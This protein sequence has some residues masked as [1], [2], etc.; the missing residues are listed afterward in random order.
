MIA[1]LRVRRAHDVVDVGARLEDQYGVDSLGSRAW[2]RCTDDRGVANAFL[3]EERMLDVF[4]KD[5]ESFRRD[6]HFF[7]APAD[8]ELSAAIDF[9]DVARVKPAVA[10]RTPGFF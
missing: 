8:V 4:R 5:V 3:R 10:E 9:S 1:E 7:L 2:R 6:D